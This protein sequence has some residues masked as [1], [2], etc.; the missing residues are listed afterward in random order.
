MVRCITSENITILS[1]KM[2]NK[3]WENGKIEEINFWHMWFETKGLKWLAEYKHR[4]NPDMLLQPDLIKCVQNLWW[5]KEVSILDVGA[6]PLTILGKKWPGHIVKI[7]AVD[8]LS[9]E[10][11]KLFEEFGVKPLVKTQYGEVEKLTDI[12]PMKY[13]DL[14]Y[15]R[16]AIDH[17][18][19]PILGIRQMLEVVKNGGYVVLSH[20]INEAEKANYEGFHQWNLCIENEKFLIWNKNERHF[21]DDIFSDMIKISFLFIEDNKW[22]TVKIKKLTFISRLFKGVRKCLKLQ[23]NTK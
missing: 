8:P 2:E 18:Y 23:T 1:M 17:S 16:N 9:E 7:T 3:K 20:S 19:D 22:I 4:L 6:G 5:K 10:Y 13:F 14:V 12:F 11:D 21:V 15:M